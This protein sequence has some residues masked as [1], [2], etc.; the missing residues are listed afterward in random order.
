MVSCRGPFLEQR[1]A[2]GV[3]HPDV[4]KHE[5][6]GVGGARRACLTGVLGHVHTMTF[7]VE[8][9]RQQIPDPQFVVDHQYVCHVS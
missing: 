5:V 8:D 2:I 6:V 3:G 4:E 7:V 1:Y 9:F